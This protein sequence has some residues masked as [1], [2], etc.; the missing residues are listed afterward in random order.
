MEYENSYAYVNNGRLDD[1][2]EGD[3]QGDFDKINVCNLRS[4]DGRERVWLS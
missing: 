2:N 3:E 1:A 4:R